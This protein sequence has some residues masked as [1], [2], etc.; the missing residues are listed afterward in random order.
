M[1]YITKIFIILKN[2]NYLKILCNFKV[3]QKKRKVSLKYPN[4]RIGPLVG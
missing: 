4:A 2:R 3:E 1:I